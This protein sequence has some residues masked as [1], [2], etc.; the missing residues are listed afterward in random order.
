MFDPI[1][2]MD[3]SFDM[4]FYILTE[5]ASQWPLIDYATVV[6]NDLTSL[7]ALIAKD[8]DYMD[9]LLVCASLEKANIEVI[10]QLQ[11]QFRIV[12][13]FSLESEY[14]TEGQQVIAELCWA[15]YHSHNFDILDADSLL[16]GVLPIRVANEKMIHNGWKNPQKSQTLYLFLHKFECATEGQIEHFQVEACQAFQVDSVAA[17]S[18]GDSKKQDA[19][20][21]SVLAI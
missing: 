19:C 12:L 7:K 11:E 16:N 4:H 15:A 5:D 8:T 20:H 1:P 14:L 6:N 13:H 9:V 10:E 3:E 2:P 17:I 21:Y 18:F